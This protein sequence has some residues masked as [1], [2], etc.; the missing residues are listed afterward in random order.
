LRRIDPIGSAL[1]LL[2]VL[3]VALAFASA[4]RAGSY[5][6]YQCSPGAPGVSP[7]WST[8]G[9]QTS[10]STVLSNACATGGAIGNYVFS[11]GQAGAVT[12]SGSSGSQVGLAI[13]VPASAPGVA[14][15]SIHAQVI[16]SSVTGDDA[17]LGFA[18]AGQS[19]P[20]LVELPYGGGDYTNTESWTLPQGARDFEAFVNC[21]TDRSSP[22]CQFADS[23]AVPALNNITL[24][25]TDGSSP[26][27]TAVSGALQTAAAN[28]ASIAGSQ[29]ISFSLAD[30]DSG[31]RSATLTLAPQGGGAAS[32]HGFDFSSSCA[33]DAWNA[34]PTAQTVSGFAVNTTALAND[35]Y[36][37]GLMVADAAGNV[38][39]VA[40]GSVIVA[41]PSTLASSLGALPGAGSGASATF[42]AGTPNGT[43][44]S[45]FAQ[46]R[47][48]A[49]GTIARTF[50]QRAVRISG[51]LLDRQGQPIRSAS[52]QVLQQVAGTSRLEAVARVLTASDGSFTGSVPAGPSRTIEVAYR[53][54]SGDAG[55]AA[56][57]SIKEA[58]GA[59]VRLSITPKSTSAQGAITLTGRVQ[60]AV[61]AR[62]A[63]VNLLVHYR[64]RWEPFR[65][66]R[67]NAQGRFH[68]VYQFEGGV[69][70]FPFRAEVPAGQAGFPFA[71]GMS[72][73]V[74]V[75][76]R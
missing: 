54:F 67:T 1:G 3:A 14:I 12:E 32:V 44:A 56:Q 41:N 33:Y 46:L 72:M 28:K 5:P 10:A 34:C 2:A 42:G 69:G 38:T 58:V 62:G 45:E 39:N 63:I 52:V 23:V 51:R 74:S 8:Y 24:T 40:L 53:A 26:A 73:V 13:N 55:Y 43:G 49:S 68:V 29:A 30:S 36:A 75:A 6:M 47:L 76:T 37:V 70:R 4:A 15:Q 16:G 57:V 7:G 60:G 18:S 20:G 17:F 71:S 35:T 9:F 31:V 19:L 11:N 21:S 59:G 61:P 27:V 25:L 66:P 48:G 64:G 50:A 65:T 22:T